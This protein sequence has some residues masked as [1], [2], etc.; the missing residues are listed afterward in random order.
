MTSKCRCV[1]CPDCNGIGSVMQRTGSYPEEDL[2]TCS[3][4]RGSGVSERCSSCE[5]TWE[6]EDWEP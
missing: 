6:R 1:S 4:C 2:Q 5:D 3:S